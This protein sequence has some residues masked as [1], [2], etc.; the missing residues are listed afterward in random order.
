MIIYFRGMTKP[1]IVAM[2][3]EHDQGKIIQYAGIMYKHIGDSLYQVCKSL[4]MYVK[5]DDLSNFTVNFTHINNLTLKEKG[6][7]RETAIKEFY[8][9]FIGDIPSTDIMFVSHGIYQDSIV[10][11][12]NNMSIDSYEHMCTYCLAKDVLGRQDRLR[13][14]DVMYDA[15]SFIINPHNAYADAVATA[16]VL[17]FLLKIKGDEETDNEILGY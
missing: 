12:E 17:S 16:D 3:L 13:L 14:S 2:D 7:D 10:M 4:N 5:Q 9:C 15:G 11:R 8:N 6:L 1:Y